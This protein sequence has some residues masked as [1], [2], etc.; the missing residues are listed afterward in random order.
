MCQSRKKLEVPMNLATKHLDVFENI[1]ESNIIYNIDETKE[2][3]IKIES[4]FL[5][6]IIIISYVNF[7]RI[8]L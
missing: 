8:L 6:I 2:P 3:R 4:I 5:S 7:I 1:D